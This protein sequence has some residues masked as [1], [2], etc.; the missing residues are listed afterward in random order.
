MKNILSTR[1]NTPHPQQLQTHALVPLHL[2]QLN[3]QRPLLPNDERLLVIR[4]AVA[5]GLQHKVEVPDETSNNNLHLIVGQIFADAV[6]WAKREGLES[7]LLVR[8]ELRV[9][10]GMVRTEPALWDE[11]VGLDKVVGVVVGGPLK[12]CDDSLEGIVSHG[13]I[14]S[15]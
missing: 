12:D 14:R 13:S 5:L 10:V 6:A 8:V 15:K 2:L 1:S 11:G 4:P 3:P 9:V 7:R